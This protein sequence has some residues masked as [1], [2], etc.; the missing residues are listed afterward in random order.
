MIL[1]ETQKRILSIVGHAKA[2]EKV[3]YEYIK[4]LIA[5]P[6]FNDE[7]LKN[8]IERLVVYKYLDYNKGEYEP[9]SQKPRSVDTRTIGDKKSV[10]VNMAFGNPK[11]ADLSSISKHN[12][13]PGGNWIKVPEVK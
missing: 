5:G 9:G 12:K 2:S 3:D 8:D 13:K 4:A 1:N 7:D 6:L 10:A 11:L